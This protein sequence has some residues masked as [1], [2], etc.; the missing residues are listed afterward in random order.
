[1][2]PVRRQI[3]PHASRL[4]QTMTDVEQALWIALRNR[5]LGG[6]KFRRQATIGAYVVDFL[7]IECNL[8]VELDGGQHS[9]EADQLRTDALEN[10]G[11][12]IARF[13]NH[14]I[15]ENLEGVLT[16]ILSMLE[17]VRP[18]PNPLPL[19]GEG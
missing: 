8:I 16:T 1:M 15:I 6:F 4:R 5:Q 17:A 13:W 14:E 10:N 18:S 19:A 9:P 2:P 3:S 7:C 11:Y 12:R